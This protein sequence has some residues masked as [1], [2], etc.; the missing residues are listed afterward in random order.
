MSGDRTTAT[1]DHLVTSYTDLWKRLN[2]LQRRLREEGRGLDAADVIAA[3]DSVE[4]LR[5]LLVQV[6]GHRF[7][8][9]HLIEKFAEQGKT[10]PVRLADQM[11]YEA[12]GFDRIEDDQNG[13]SES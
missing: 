10:W 9:T 3:R 4:M 1:T 11:L 13:R 5:D 2:V 8:T 7:D 12:A 6:H